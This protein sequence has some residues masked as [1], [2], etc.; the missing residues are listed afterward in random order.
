MPEKGTEDERTHGEKMQREKDE[1][2][3]QVGNIK[4]KIMKAYYIITMERDS[5]TS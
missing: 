4:I 3:R 2:W 1:T 5:I